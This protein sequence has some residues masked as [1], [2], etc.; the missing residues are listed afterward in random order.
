[1]PG[2]IEKI[3]GTAGLLDALGAISMNRSFT[4]FMQAWIYSLMHDTWSNMG[5]MIDGIILSTTW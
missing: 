5:K 3:R 1:M 2:S 4:D